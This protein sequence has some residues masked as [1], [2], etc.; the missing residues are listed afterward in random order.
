MLKAALIILT[1]P[2]TVTTFV[3]AE[4]FLRA[5]KIVEKIGKKITIPADITQALDT[6]GW[7]VLLALPVSFL[8]LTYII[9]FFLVP[10]AVLISD[11]TGMRI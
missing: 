9:L 7:L 1:S 11:W 8:V 6:I 2:I 4:V 10:F 5:S 3:A